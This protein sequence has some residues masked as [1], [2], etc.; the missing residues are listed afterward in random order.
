M[1]LEK[2]DA[3]DLVWE[4]IRRNKTFRDEYNELPV[5]EHGRKLADPGFCWKWC[6]NRP[7][8]PSVSIDVIKSKNECEKNYQRNHPILFKLIAERSEIWLRRYIEQRVNENEKIGKNGICNK[9]DSFYDLDEQGWPEGALVSEE[10]PSDE[11]E[12]EEQLN[13]EQII[14]E[15]LAGKQLELFPH[16]D[17]ELEEFED[18]I[19]DE[20]FGCSFGEYFEANVKSIPVYIKYLHLY[21][22]LGD[23]LKTDGI[24][25]YENGVI[26]LPEN[27]DWGCLYGEGERDEEIEKIKIKIENLV[28]DNPEYIEEVRKKHEM[29][30]YKDPLIQGKKVKPDDLV[31]GLAEDRADYAIQKRKKRAIEKACA[32]IANTPQNIVFSPAKKRK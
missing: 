8:N 27:F 3:K 6:I 18:D 30:E 29:S 1:A 25:A 31:N 13:H 28:S 26:Q 2:I 12:S 22:K 9:F 10:I 7:Y 24:I 16:A 14:V 23:T 19:D 32:L 5:G 11:E 21:D 4:L 20:D 17:E 15:S